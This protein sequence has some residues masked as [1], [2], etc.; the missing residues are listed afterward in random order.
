[1][2]E[3]PAALAAAAPVLKRDGS[4][5]GSAVQMAA[6][7]EPI[8][9]GGGQGVTSGD[10]Y[11]ASGPVREDEKIDRRVA[12][13]ALLIAVLFFPLVGV[14]NAVSFLTDADRLGLGVDPRQPW[15]LEG[16][17][18]AVLV[19]L[20]PLIALLER[21]FPIEAEG[22]VTRLAI[23]LA[24]SVAF[25]ALHVAGMIILRKLAFPILL[26]EPYSFFDEPLQDLVYEY[27]KDLLPY[28][29]LVLVLS[30]LRSLEEHRRE[31]QAARADARTTGKLTLKAGGRTIFLDA[32]SFESAAAAGNYVELRASGT[33]HLVRIG[34]AAL[35]GQLAEAGI[36][37]VR[38]HRSHLVNV[39]QVREIAPARDGDFR[40]RMADGSELRGSR[41]FRHL[42]PG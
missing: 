35:G 6:Q 36:E 31:A 38:I 10:R 39:A 16:T 22:W 7:T 24:A 30:L 8:G 42:L 2:A 4:S 40:V 1:V 11:A 28:A 19:A 18:V 27:R 20:V 21:R 26:G 34:L 41:R 37:T 14:I 3:R 33:T 13:R 17:S 12:R 15:V 29:A 5:G 9:V 32:R 23:Y 25:S